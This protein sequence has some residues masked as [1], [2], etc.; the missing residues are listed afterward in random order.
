M[1]ALVRW[2]IITLGLLFF[3][4]GRSYIGFVDRFC[5]TSHLG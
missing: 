2:S 4:P 3:Y 5:A 1:A